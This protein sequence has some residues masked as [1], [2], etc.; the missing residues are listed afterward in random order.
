MLEG[1]AGAEL[2][3]APAVRGE[4]E[5]IFDT[6]RIATFRFTMSPAARDRIV[7]DPNGAGDAYQTVS[8]MEFQ[9][10]TLTNVGMK[11]VGTNRF[12]FSGNPKQSFKLSFDEFSPGREWRGLE[13]LKF[14][15]G[16]RSG[17]AE[18][19]GFRAF[20]EFGVVAPRAAPAKVFV[21]GEYLGVFVVEEVVR[22][23]FFQFHLGIADPDGNLYKI[24]RRP[25]DTPFEGDHYAF[26][27]SNPGSYVPHPWELETNERTGEFS[28]VVAFVNVLTNVRQAQRRTELERLIEM[29]AFLSY[30]AVLQAIGDFD[31]ALSGDAR[32]PNNHFWYHRD[33]TDKLLV[34]PWDP[35][36]TWGASHWIGFDDKV[37][38]DV[39]FGIDP[40]VSSAF[41]RSSTRATAW[42]AADAEARRQYEAKLRQVV[43][44]VL[45]D[46]VGHADAIRGLV[47]DAVDDDPHDS[48]AD[49]QAIIGNVKRWVPRRSAAIRAQLSAPD[50]ET[51]PPADDGDRD[52]DGVPDDDDNCPDAANPGQENSDGG[53]SGNACDPDDD[54]DKVKDVDDNCDLVP[55]AGQAD[56]DGDGIGDACES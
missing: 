56:A 4:S 11:A 36:N 37:D 31:S 10:E 51:A 1:E 28:D 38:M 3:I 40:S 34:V 16:I 2:D 44:T 15:G 52:G 48:F 18:Y 54:N 35:S 30:L 32:S 47:E 46:M 22:K 21:N 39:Y 25:N 13:Q 27:G 7:F 24:D 42:I 8:V 43:D 26:R 17:L 6:S 12:R 49:F 53:S 55:N 50:D 20:R 41:G 45:P 23:E 5:P 33:D 29:D 14:E 9:G 19:F